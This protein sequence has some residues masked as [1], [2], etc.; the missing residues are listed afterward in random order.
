MNS[1]FVL[2]QAEAVSERVAKEAETDIGR[3]TK[4]Y[5]LVLQRKPSE[6]EISRAMRFL[7][8]QLSASKVPPLAKLGQV[9]LDCNE[10]VFID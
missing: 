5:Q 6:R 7:N 3:I 2:E 1:P 9:L 10:M 4:L 8:A